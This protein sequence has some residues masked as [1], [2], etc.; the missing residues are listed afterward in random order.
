MT[1][2][3]NEDLYRQALAAFNRGGREA[4]FPFFDEAVEIYDPDLPG[5]GT[6]RGH[7][8]LRKVLGQLLDGFE[9]LKVRD[10]ELHSTGDRVVGLIHTYGRGLDGLEIELR[11]AH[12][13][14]YRDGKIVYWRLYL[15]QREAL[16]DAGFGD[17]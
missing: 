15:D 9:V 12:T 17:G 3:S 11:D 6:S 10:F 4:L 5:G 13:W 2:N 16:S 1:D 14:T 8:G 7:D